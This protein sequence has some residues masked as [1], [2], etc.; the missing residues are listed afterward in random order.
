MAKVDDECPDELS[1]RVVN[2]EYK[3]WKKNSP[4]LYDLVITHALEWPSLTVQWFPEKTEPVGKDYSAQ[5]LILGTHTSEGEQNYLM[6][7]EVQLPLE[8]TETDARQYEDEDREAG[9]FG[10]ANGK[11]QIIQQIN[12]E[13]EVN[14][15]RYM[16][17]N[18]FLIAT[19]TVNA[20]V[21]VFDYS[22]HPSKPS[23]DGI[24]NP[25]LRLRGHKTE[26]YGLSWSHFREGHLLS[27]SD[28][29]QI[30][31]W[32][33]S[34]ATKQNKTIEAKQIF[35]YHLGVVEDVAWHT[36]HEHMFGSVGDDHH[37]LIWDTRGP[38]NKPSQHVNAHK[39]EV[40]CLS[41]NPFSEYVVAT[42]S[43][44]RTV[45]IHDMRRLVTPLH[46]LTNHVEEVFQIG[47]NPKVE[48]I[49]ASCGADRRLMLWDMARIGKE[50]SAEDAE[51]GPPELLF[52]HGGHTSKIS[53]FSWN[54]NDD[55]VVASVAEDNILQIW[56]M[57]ENIFLDDDD[58][59]D[60]PENMRI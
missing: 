30:C 8:D 48:T 7:A 20:E 1:E 38:G 43:A 10:V 45:V 54:A 3:I 47:W 39:A 22:K 28:D 16:P 13:G 29:A 51:D 26:G 37:L 53:D 46:T 36:L 25:D 42:G 17:Q 52:I 15:A 59:E 12:H 27:G 4:F 35:N 19:K 41:F 11:V 23:N 5:R 32:D 44:D 24:C 6:L 18:P 58:W 9:G 50:Q 60:L 34:A 33:I 56:Q 57:A 55:W 31:L 49:M 2:E 21:Y 40:N 14:R